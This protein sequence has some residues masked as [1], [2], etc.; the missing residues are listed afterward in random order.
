MSKPK[1]N[2]TARRR[3]WLALIPERLEP[4]RLFSSFVVNTTADSGAGSLRQAILD[5]NA[6]KGLDTVSFQIAGT[7]VQTITPLTPLPAITDPLVIDGST[8]PGFTTAPL[9]Q[10]SGSSAGANADGLDLTG[11]NSTVQD[12]VISNF[13]GSAISI[14]NAAGG[15]LIE[16]NYLGTDPTGRVAAGNGVDGVA[17]SGGSA[18]NQILDNLISAN[19]VKSNF[20][21]IAIFGLGTNSNV[22]SGNQIGTDLGGTHALG[23]GQGIGISGGASFNQVNGNLVSGNGISNSSPNSGV[24]LFGNGTNSNVLRGNLIGT[25][26]SGILALGNGAEGVTISDQASSNVLVGNTISANDGA[27]LGYAGV[28]IWGTGTNSNVLTGNRIGTDSAGVRPL[29]NGGAGVFIQLGAQLN[30]VGTNGDG[31]NDASEANVISANGTLGGY[32]GV[33]IDGAGSNQNIVAGNFIGTDITGTWPLGNNGIGVLV[34]GGAQSNRIGVNGADPGAAAERNIISA[35][36]LGGNYPGVELYGSGTSNNVVAGNY[37]GLAAGGNNALG[38]GGVGIY[39]LGAAHSNRIGT[40]GDGVGDALERNVISGNTYQGIA[41]QGVATDSNV[42]AGNYIGTS[43]SGAA[44]PG[45]GNLNNGIWILQGPMNN[46]IGTNGTDVNAVGEGNLIANNG[47]AGVAV[48]DAGSIDNTIRGNSIHNNGS[49]GIDLGIDGMNLNHGTGM[50]SGPNNYQNWPVLLA[51]T[52]GASTSISGTL[53]SVAATSYTLDFYA[54]SGADNPYAGAGDRWLGSYT[55][56]TDS[57]GH[58][59]FSANVGTASPGEWVTAT[60]TDSAGNTSEF[61]SPI[62]LPAIQPQ[63]NA[64]TWTGIGPA[65]VMESQV[66][67]PMVTGRVSVAA[68]DPNNPNVMYI[69]VDG[70][71]VW[72]STDWLDPIPH[73]TPLTDNEPSLSFG[74]ISYTALAVAPSNSQVIYAA[75]STPGGGILKSIDGGATW[76][77]LAGSTFSHASFAS[78]VVSP[79]DANTLYV[80]VWYGATGGGGVY[81]SIDGGQTWNNTTSFVGAGSAADLVINPTT[82]TT[83]YAG[84]IGIGGSSGIYR[85]VDGGGH[86]T[87][88]TTGVLAGG[89]VGASIRLAIAPS[90]PNTVYAT[91][92]DTALGNSPSGLPHRY[93]T[94][95]GGTTWTALTALN[96]ATQPAEPRYW[97]AVLSVDPLNS[98]IVYINGDHALYQSTDAGKTWSKIYDEDP[99]NVYFDDS[100]A[101]VMTGDR[102]IYRQAGGQASF[103]NKQGDL[104]NTEFYTLT[105]DPADPNTV[106]GIAQDHTNS[107][108]YSGNTAWNYTG[109]GDEVGRIIVDPTLPSRIYEYDPKNTLA[110][111]TGMVLRSDDGGATFTAMGSGI[112][113]TLAGFNLAYA[114]QKAFVM[115]PSNHDRLLVGTDTVYET[116]TDGT[117][118][119]AISPALSAGQFIT[120]LGVASSAPNTVYAATSDGKIFLTTNDSTWQEVDTGLSLQTGNHVMDLQIDPAN[121]QHVVVVTGSFLGGLSGSNHVFVTSNGGVSWTNITGNL[122]PDDA[123][124]SLAVDWR[125]STPRLYVGTLRG[126]F[127]STDSGA[128]WSPFGAGLPNTIVTDLQLST[129][130]NRLAAATYGRGAF[131]INVPTPLALLGDLNE[132]GTVNLADLLILTR[133]MGQ[134]GQTW[135][136]GDLNGDGS[137][138]LADF[139]ILTRNFGKTAAAATAVASATPQASTPAQSTTSARTTV[140]TAKSPA[141]TTVLQ[142]QIAQKQ[143]MPTLSAVDVLTRKNHR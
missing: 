92:F 100:G 75:V 120:A 64:G 79:T 91:V 53:T 102:G 69:G 60:A 13:T 99:V 130:Y 94:T 5:A 16:N 96:P 125:F 33:Q 50:M 95:D 71:G 108:K 142:N 56:T 35:N 28:D 83:L 98:S 138:G 7:G 22:V 115:D 40:D 4:R 131:E 10:I 123:G 106:Y 68:A 57:T 128:H 66:N 18:A 45:L 59:T 81:K 51:G 65:P 140:K 84:I 80:S 134:S 109:G 143:T 9:I 133:H 11:G 17:I 8:Q 41:I 101:V 63:I 47:Y 116:T 73:W 78:L 114:S 32:A 34:S 122:P 1:T 26:F 72:K 104:Q 48:S 58:V 82:P 86:W 74:N 70:G 19:G 29:G 43:A 135:Q 118:W 117:T 23:N 3:M 20:P 110:N 93:V 6:N 46:R 31:V 2:R 21:G 52:A 67:A 89:S 44:V 113:T 49:Q 97:H 111:S 27:G 88:L 126:V 14:Y 24:A 105:L 42:V 38:N 124:Q 87:Q 129:K 55:V 25:D 62:K 90:S 127:L 30:Q 107:M 37:V 12:L 136:T 121:P 137:V 39:L 76:T 36:G 119:K 54:N 85:T 103:Q 77:E 112:P 61:S 141:R 15:N 139:L 132:D